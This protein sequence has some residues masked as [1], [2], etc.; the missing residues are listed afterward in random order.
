MVIP[1]PTL[2]IDLDE[3]SCVLTGTF[4]SCYV[5][6]YLTRIGGKLDVVTVTFRSLTDFVVEDVLDPE[7]MKDDLLEEIGALL[8][9]AW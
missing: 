6:A 7:G 8:G 4:K 1:H 2:V 5:F 9:E 3:D